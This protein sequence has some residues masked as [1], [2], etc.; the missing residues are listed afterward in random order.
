MGGNGAAKRSGGGVRGSKKKR[1]RCSTSDDS[2]SSL[3]DSS[4][5]SDSESPGR[6]RP[7]RSS[8]RK[9]RSGHRRRSRKESESPEV[10]PS[11]KAKSERR[12]R[13]DKKRKRDRHRRRTRG[14]GGRKKGAGS[15]HA[16][17][18]GSS[19]D[20]E[21]P[22]PEDMVCCILKKFPE[23]AGDLRQLL[24]VVDSGQAVDVRGIS[25]RSMSKLLKKLFRSL[26]L[27]QNDD[28]VFLLAPRRLPTLDV[29][30]SLLSSHVKGSGISHSG[31]ATGV[32]PA[33][34]DKESIQKN[35]ADIGPSE[36]P[37]VKPDSLSLRRRFIGPEMPSAELLAAAAE[38]TEAETA[39]RNADLEVDD[40][41][42]IGPAPPAVVAEAASANEAERF[43]EVAR[44]IGADTDKPY[45]VLGVNWKMSTENVKKKYWKLS[46]MV[47]PDKCSHPQ[48]HQAFVILNKAFKLLQDPDE[49]KA[50]EEK[51]KLK[52]EEA[53]FKAEL[54]ALR[55]A[56]QW[57]KLQGISMEG[58]DVLL[59]ET[60]QPPKRD[61]WM[62]TLPP[63][64]KD[65]ITMQSTSFSRTRKEGRGDTSIWTD[66][67]LD[68]AQKAKQSY[69]EAYNRTTAVASMD[70]EKNRASSVA[71]LVDKFNRAKRPISL[72]QKH[73]EESS[74]PKRKSKLPEKEEDWV[75]QH[76][77]KPWDRE[78][79]LTAGRKK[80]NLDAKNM[81]DGLASR[82]SSGSFQRDFL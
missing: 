82:F 23:A 24:Q 10:P 37:R 26:K 52:E 14:D 72:V 61:E 74:R 73:Q 70:D 57:R 43:E 63:E 62:T 19:S 35:E 32:Q 79:D 56:A 28:G 69:L 55:E 51:M 76:P 1:H 15:E 71:D 33:S 68:K 6:V 39:L 75:G 31:S 11:K 46:L 25:D 45:D 41:L 67:P 49:R 3:S 21:S 81:A 44:I 13:E 80:V 16:S 7:G 47:H 30:G 60:E 27:K 54:Q 40:D 34:P 50:M 5:G 22:K 2:T 12:G 59:A 29:V 48:A 38:L 17:S 65:G 9:H 66:N 20:Y 58:D 18:G 64:R 42:F 78:K 36:E 4:S 53:A 77:W 8:R